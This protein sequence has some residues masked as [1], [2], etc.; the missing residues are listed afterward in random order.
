LVLALALALALAALRASPDVAAAD[1]AGDAACLPE[2]A[3]PGIG[4][5]DPFRP[6]AAQATALNA[7]AKPLYRQGKWDEARAKYR[8]AQAADPQSLAPTLNIACSFVRQE[9]FAEAT[10]E[11]LKLLEGGYVPWSREIL[12]AADLGALKAAPE[13][14]RIRQAMADNAQRWGSELAGDVLFVARQRAPL[15]LPDATGDG[16]VVL[17]LG[18]HQEVFAWSPVTARYRQVTVEDGRVLAMVPSA[19]RQS[20]L[21][22]TAEKLVRASGAPPA[23]RRAAVHTLALGSLSPGPALPIEGDLRRLAIAPAGAGFAL[24]IEG[25]KMSGS[26]SLAAGQGRLAPG[27]RLDERRAG[28]RLVVLSPAGV[29][30]PREQALPSRGPCR[31]VVARDKKGADGVAI[32]EVSAPGRKPVALSTRFGAGLAGL[33]IH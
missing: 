8:A 19:D 1:A 2:Q 30:S 24:A 33:A 3:T 13:M 28:A 15:K 22:V 17:V 14:T 9:R 18:L 31:A 6:P 32:V 7:E 20:L 29:A 21:Y 10:T 4:A 25:D 12:T 11:V 16:P 23:F 5:V 27:A 26:F